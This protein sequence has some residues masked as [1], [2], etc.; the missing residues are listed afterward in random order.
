MVLTAHALARLLLAGPDLEVTTWD[1]REGEQAAIEQ[2]VAT[3]LAV[4]LGMDIA[5]GWTV[6]GA[7]T[8][9]AADDSARRG[10]ER[11]QARWEQAKREWVG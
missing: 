6:D 11:A 9:W 1:P 5:P 3:D 4:V 2:V 7:E 8:V 10:I